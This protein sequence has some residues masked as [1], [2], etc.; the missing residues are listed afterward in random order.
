MISYEKIEGWIFVVRGHKVML[1]SDL[2]R[3]YRV[4][5]KELNKAVKRNLDRFPFDFMFQLTSQES[6]SLR[7]QF[8]TSKGD[9]GGRRY[10][11]YAFTEQ[12]VAMLSSVLNSESAIQVNIQIMRAFIKLKEMAM[13][14][15]NIY[16]QL[17]ALE[18]KYRKHDRRFGNVFRVIKEL[19]NNTRKPPVIEKNI[20]RIAGFVKQDD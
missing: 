18:K 7:F 3:L 6:N 5:T 2:A 1:D 15:K 17:E 9:R 20:P 13:T 14:H 16:Q 10:L 12:G 4:K 19:V 11:P 8:G